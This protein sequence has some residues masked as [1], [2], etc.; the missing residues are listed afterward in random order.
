MTRALVAALFLTTTA[1]AAEFEI[2]PPREMARVTM[3]CW[4]DKQVTVA[5]NNADYDA[6][7]QG[8]LVEK[9]DPAK[10]LVTFWLH[11]L[12]G[13]GAVVISHPTGEECIALVVDQAQ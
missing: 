3:P 6:V 11:A 7:V 5:F 1:S 8:L 2:S 13:R 12:T 10:P 9:T 4:Q